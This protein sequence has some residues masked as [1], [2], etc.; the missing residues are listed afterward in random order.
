MQLV[1]I[2]GLA[3][4]LSMD[5]FA[6]SICKGLAMHKPKLRHC[7]TVGLWFGVFQ[8]LMPLIGFE[9]GEMLSA[10]AKWGKLIACI[11]LVLIG[12]NM[13][14][15]SLDECGDADAS[16]SVSKMLPLAI[17]TSID[18]LAAGFTIAFIG[19]NV[20]LSAGII[21]AMTF[22][23]SAFGVKTGSALGSRWQSGAEKLGGGVLILL[24][25]KLF[26]EFLGVF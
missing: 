3:I 14:R 23:I 19:V 17:A 20:I 5:A 26:L 25:I 16:V 2:L 22:C 24:G 21:G 9:V 18:A 15:E 11:L 10:I 13:L 8:M 6:V 1:T 12:L 7:I 4:G